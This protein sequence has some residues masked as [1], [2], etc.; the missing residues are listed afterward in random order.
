MSAQDG[1][2]H[3]LDRRLAVAAGNHDHRDRELR[4]PVRRERAQRNERIR[5]RDQVAPK[6][7]GTV[8]RDQRCARAARERVRHEVV[9]V[10]TLALQ[11]DEK[12]ARRERAR[13]GRHAQEPDVGAV[14]GPGDGTG[15]SRGVHHAPLRALIA[16]AAASASEK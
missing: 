14:E 7:G 5:R 16:A 11:R 3:L 6:L 1:R 4:A 13:V 8:G 10:E 2:Q 15:G 12:V 9:S